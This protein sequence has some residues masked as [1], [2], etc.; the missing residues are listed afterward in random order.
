MQDPM[1]LKTYWQRDS[2]DERL[3]V[4]KNHKGSLWHALTNAVTE[5]A[6]TYCGVAQ[7]DQEKEQRIKKITNKD[8]AAE[9]RKQ[10]VQY[11]RTVDKNQ[12]LSHKW[13]SLGCTLVTFGLG[14]FF[15]TLMFG[16]LS[17]AG[18]AILASH[19]PLAVGVL[20]AYTAVCAFTMFRS[21]Y[22]HQKNYAARKKIIECLT[23]KSYEEKPWWSCFTRRDLTIAKVDVAASHAESVR[24]ERPQ[25]AQQLE[26]RDTNID[27]EIRGNYGRYGAGG[28]S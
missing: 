10:F 13:F 4:I 18:A 22:L 9:W 28:R 15:S 27:L 17:R 14:V 1:N 8:Y 7:D 3:M 26:E 16:E 5:T 21:N 2:Q 20:V 6:P 19:T 11:Q 25:V 23:G 24:T 12:R